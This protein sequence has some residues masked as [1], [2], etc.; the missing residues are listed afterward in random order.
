VE[1]HERVAPAVEWLL[2][3]VTE[4]E[5]ELAKY[6]G[7]EPTIAEEMA[8]LSN[9][10]DAV[11]SLCHETRRTGSL[12]VTPEAVEQA[13]AGEWTAATPRP[14]LPWA[15]VMD[16]GDLSMFLDDLISAALGRWQT[17]AEGPIPDRVTLAAIEKA[18]QDWRT[19]G[20]GLR[21]DEPGTG[22]GR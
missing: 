18:C 19:P 20:H 2:D 17:D 14:A 5:A 22:E 10:L 15:H 7:H 21:G 12:G 3:R 8:Y 11:L 6:V 9:S 1:I 4:L 16:D 13:A